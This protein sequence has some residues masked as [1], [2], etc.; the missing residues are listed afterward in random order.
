MDLTD[1]FKTFSGGAELSEREVLHW[2]R[3]RGFTHAHDALMM[4]ISSQT[5]TREEASV[6]QR[7]ARDSVERAA[8]D[9]AFLPSTGI[10]FELREGVVEALSAYRDLTSNDDVLALLEH[11]DPQ[12]CALFIQR[13][14]QRT[15]EERSGLERQVQMAEESTAQLCTRVRELD[16]QLR[17]TVAIIAERMQALASSVDPIR[18][19][20]LLPLLRTVAML[21]SSSAVRAAARY[22]MLTL[23]KRP[24]VEHRIAIVQEWLC[25]AQEAPSRVLEQELIPELYTLVNARVFER[26]L[27]ALDCAAAVAPLLR[28]SPQVRYSLC[29]GLLRPLCEDDTSAVRSELPRCLS[30]LWGGDATTTGTTVTPGPSASAGS[31]SHSNLGVLLPSDTSAARSSSTRTSAVCPYGVSCVPLSPTQK[32]YFMGMLVQLATDSS[33]RTVRQ[34]AQTQLCEALYPLFLRDGVL[35]IQF[36]PLLLSVIGMETTQLLLL[37]GRDKKNGGGSTLEPPNASAGT[38]T[39]EESQKS[40]PGRTSASVAAALSLGNVMTLIQ[41]LHAALRC[42]AAELLHS[43]EVLECHDGCEGNGGTLSSPSLSSTY[44]RVVLPVACNLLCPLLSKVHF[45]SL[46]TGEEN[47]MLSGADASARLCGPLCALCATL[48]SLVPLLG[49]QAWQEVVQCLKGLLVSSP[50]HGIEAAVVAENPSAMNTTSPPTLPLQLPPSQSA[51]DASLSLHDLERGRLHFVFSFFLFLCG[52]TMSLPQSG[53]GAAAAAAAAAAPDTRETTAIS[54]P[55]PSTAPTSDLVPAHHI[56]DESLH[57]VARYIS[58]NNKD[59]RSPRPAPL[60]ACIQ[61]VAALAPFAME[62]YEMASGISGLVSFLVASPDERRRLTAVVLAH[63]TCAML[64]NERLKVT[65]LIE[66]L[67]PLLED[68]QAAVQEAALSG[69]LS[70]SIALTEPRAQEKTIRPVLRAAD[71][72]GCTSRYTR[73]LLQQLCQLMERMPAEPREALLYPQLSVLMDRLAE[74]YVMLLSQGRLA[75]TA[76]SA[77]SSS[78]PISSSSGGADTPHGGTSGEEDALAAHHWEDTMLLLQALLSSIVR[79]AVVTPTLVYRY[80]LPGIHQLASDGVLS[81]CSPAVRTRWLRLQKNYNFFMES[82]NTSRLAASGAT[83]ASGARN[84]AS[85]LDRFKDELKRRL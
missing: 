59:F 77:S 74:L 26:R 80:L 71:A 34:A 45:A 2:L 65:L 75:A 58:L 84:V 12:L 33:S 70:I 63:D 40:A 38:T 83:P 21:G 11:W 73:C 8:T 44:V 29:Q 1:S 15:N 28:G 36:V 78:F 19:D 14:A 46:T 37:K 17:Q 48:A 10:L 69:F 18:K 56:Q 72:T 4:E 68:S 81:G 5:L 55:S 24:M 27:L 64:A 31:M 85:F 62:S 20:I 50:Q 61:C 66:P 54:A 25:V 82:N 47:V 41:L 13:G 7:V 49:A 57:L 76:A 16:T 3:H 43:H 60:M 35:L 22:M 42:V 52:K 67:L 9:G 32:T 53:T 6:G 39:R 23:Y 79:C 30:L 51:L